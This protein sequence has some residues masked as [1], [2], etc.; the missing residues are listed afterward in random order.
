VRENEEEGR[1]R[2]A[3]LK[4]IESIQIARQRV[5]RDLL[6]AKQVLQRRTEELEQQRE[7]FEVTLAS[8]GDAVVTTDVMGNVTFL[9][10]IAES[11]MGWMQA[12]A[13]EQPLTRVFDIVNEDTREPVENPVNTALHTG[14]VVTLATHTSLRARDGREIAIEDSAAPIRNHRG[15]V[16]G[17]VMVFRDVTHRRAA[18]RELRRSEQLLTDFFEN[19][20]VGLHWVGPDGTVIR[21]NQTELDLLGYAREEYIGHHIAEFHADAHV[22]KDILTRL[23]CGESIQ[24]YE[25]RLR[26]KDGSIKHVLISSNVLWEEGKFIHTRCFTRDVTA[27][28]LAEIALREQVAV[29]E[30]AEAALLEADRR[31]DEFLA[32]LAHELR[33]PMAPLRNGLRLAHKRLQ[34]TELLP[35]VEMMDRQVTHLTRLVNDLMD[36]SRVTRG[37]IELRRAPVLLKDV[38]ERSVEAVRPAIDTKGHALTIQLADEDMYVDGDADRLTQII[39][40]LLANSAKYTPERGAIEVTCAREGQ[41][42]VIKVEDSG[43]GIPADQLDRVFDMFSQVRSHQSRSEGGLG[44]GLALVKTLVKMH[45][46]S[47][48]VASAGHGKGSTFAVRLPLNTA[49]KLRLLPPNPVLTEGEPLRILV[50]DDNFDSA[51]SLRMVLQ[52]GGHEV[53]VAQ[54]GLK[55]LQV[56]ESMKPALIFMDIGMPIMDGIEATRRIRAHPAGATAYIVALTGWGQSDDRARSAEAGV[57]RHVVKPVGH[58]ELQEIC[59]AARLSSKLQGATGV[60]AADPSEVA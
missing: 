54:D 50:A 52:S 10:P 3:A 1:L 48:H 47:I 24:G 46:G 40:N 11:I 53:E 29:R 31:K 45:D 49:E 16:V 19:A 42:A 13:R 33:N 26:C 25:A 34:G 7:W 4:N 2:T 43:I 17:A 5:E 37:V 44:I 14:Q 57:S 59:D 15:D 20:A 22:I 55:A 56:F 32:V 35:V 39:S 12:D 60:R 18:E 38:I 6:E 51:D 23:G 9:N 36:I 30:R 58:E 28:K 8:I 27:Q 21:V 41:D